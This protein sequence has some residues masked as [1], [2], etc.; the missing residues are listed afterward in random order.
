MVAGSS[1]V[2][3]VVTMAMVVAADESSH[4]GKE[5]HMVVGDTSLG[6]VAGS[7]SFGR[8]RYLC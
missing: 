3:M 1:G 4:G 5:S 7:T 6:K 2:V 8:G